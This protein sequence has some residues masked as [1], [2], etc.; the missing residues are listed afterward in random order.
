[1]RFARP[2]NT[3]RR[4]RYRVVILACFLGVAFAGFSHIFLP[5]YHQRVVRDHSSPL[6]GVQMAASA[7]AVKTIQGVSMPRLIYGT[8]WKKDRTTD[9]VGQALRA[10]FRGIDTA[11][12]PKHYDEARVG[13]AVSTFIASGGARREDI[14]LQTKFTPIGGHDPARIPYDPRAPLEEQVRQSVATSLR[15]LRTSYVDSLVIHSPLDTVADTLRVWRVLEG[16]VAEGKIRQLGI[17]NCYSDR[18]FHALWNQT[19]VKPSVLQNRFYP[20]SGYDVALRQFCREAG[21]VYQSFWTLTGNPHVLQHRTFN[22]IAQQH[23]LL[24]QQLF[25]RFVMDLGLAPLTGTTSAQHMAEDLAVLDHPSL[26][27]EEMQ[28]IL[29]LLP[30]AA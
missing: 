27:P 24:P 28:A 13:E 5:R 7:H 11:C 10:G 19:S 8:A 9:L 18:F 23:K 15:N 25:F 17:S 16:F 12:Q 30:A 22:T 29:R 20:Q 3:Q 14:F 6:P 1:M 21:V 4:Y 26:T 2:S